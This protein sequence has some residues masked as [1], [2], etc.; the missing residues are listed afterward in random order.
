MTSALSIAMA[1]LHTCNNSLSRVPNFPCVDPLSHYYFFSLVLFAL[2]YYLARLISLNVCQI[3][4]SAF[5]CL[6]TLLRDQDDPRVLTTMRSAHTHTYRRESDL[7]TPFALFA[8]CVK[9]G[10][11]RVC[12]EVTGEIRKRDQ[13]VS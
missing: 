7:A 10:Y 4:K 3:N 12:M 8:R 13:R 2:R 11:R 6:R 5:I 1:T 9:T